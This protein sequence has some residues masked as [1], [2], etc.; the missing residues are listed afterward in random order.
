MHA[1]ARRA[2]RCA[3]AAASSARSFGAASAPARALSP[4]HA[5]LCAAAEAA[6]LAWVDAAVL[7]LNL[8]PFAHAPRAGGTLRC[9]A[10][11]AGAL[12][13]LLAALRT[14]AD[15]LAAAPAAPPARTTLLVAPRCAQLRELRPF[16]A[17]LAA[18]DD[19]L[20][21]AGL[22]GTL[23][24]VGFHPH[25]CF[26]GEA[27]DDAATYS[28]RS[29]FPT[30][31]L[32]RECDVDAALVGAPDAG[33]AVPRRNAATLRGIGAEELEARLDALRRGA[34]EGALFGGGGGGGAGGSAGT[35]QG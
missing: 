14:E 21:A 17:A 7:A 8:C 29:P 18:A 31:H 32:L 5:A 1:A 30:L 2:R 35:A 4:R 16:L 27:A 3:S 20:D 9:V 13:A 25:M 26:A 22:R 23:Q 10:T 15:A 11:P 33:E 34:L 6:T 12:P 19:A 28:N 24:L